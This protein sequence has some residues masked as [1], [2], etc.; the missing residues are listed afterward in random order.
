MTD[1]F[2]SWPGVLVFEAEPFAMPL[3]LLLAMAGATEGTAG[4]MGLLPFTGEAEDVPCCA[5]CCEPPPAA[6]WGALEATTGGPPCLFVAFAYDLA[7]G[8]AGTAFEG[9]VVPEAE[10]EAA[11]VRV[12]S[13]L[14]AWMEV[15][16]RF[17]CWF[18]L[19]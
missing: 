13:A 2:L 3:P 4:G 19:L 15:F 12:W 9:D 6:G 5:E 14:V 17:A 16:I 7:V 18:F 10:V 8:C 11:F 1:D